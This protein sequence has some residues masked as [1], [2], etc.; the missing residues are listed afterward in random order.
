M[1]IL[2]AFSLKY[3][4]SIQGNMFKRKEKNE[5]LYLKDD[6]KDLRRILVS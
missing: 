4:W 1:T 5:R 2:R 3:I 6:Y